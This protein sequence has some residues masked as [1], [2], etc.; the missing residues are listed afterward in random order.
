MNDGKILNRWLRD[1]YEACNSNKSLEDFA[2]IFD[3]QRFLGTP[4]L[5][6]ED[7]TPKQHA[8]SMI[9]MYASDS[10]ISP[11]ATTALY[12]MFVLGDSG[13]SKY[14]RQKRYTEDEIIDGFY[15]VYLQ[16]IQNH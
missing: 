3:Y 1:L 10:Q 9:H 2:G 5:N 4:D 8:I 13:V 14:I 7:F 16:E 6:S 15:D 11:N 12:P